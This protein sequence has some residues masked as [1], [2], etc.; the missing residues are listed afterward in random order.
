MTKVILVRHGQ[1]EW[2]IQGKYQGHSD[3]ELSPLGLEQAKLVGKRLAKEKIDAVY[4]SDLKRAVKTAEY[5]AN[6]HTLKVNIIEQFREISFGDW[7]G[8]DY[9]TINEKWPGKVEL[10]FKNAELNVIP[11]GETFLEV[12]ERSCRVMKNLTEKHADKTIVI[13]SHG[14]TIRTLI[15]TALQLRLKYIWNLRQDN[16]AVNILNYYDTQTVVE[17]LND[18]HHLNQC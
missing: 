15:A 14:G 18:T 2:N 6:E 12:T 10:F 13:V 5:I 16:T 8:L 3:I 1:T 7:E 17:L 11:N 4:A 9:K